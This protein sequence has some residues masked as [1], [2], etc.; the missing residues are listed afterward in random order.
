MKSFKR[1]DLERVI[2]E[3]MSE[4]IGVLGM[5]KR[6]TTRVEVF[7]STLTHRS[8]FA[9]FLLFFTNTVSSSCQKSAGKAQQQ[10]VSTDYF[11]IMSI[12]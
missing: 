12:R 5:V 9:H 4:F 3:V 6:R 10:V 2:Q 11:T 1:H 8:S 7:P